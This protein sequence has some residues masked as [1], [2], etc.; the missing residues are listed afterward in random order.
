M[1]FLL[2]YK[3][4]PTRMNLTSAV[5]SGRHCVKTLTRILVV[6]SLSVA[7]NIKSNYIYRPI[8]MKMRVV[9]SSKDTLIFWCYSIHK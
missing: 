8:N 5:V 9:K 4:T 6:S 2:S 3:K 7:E 1:F